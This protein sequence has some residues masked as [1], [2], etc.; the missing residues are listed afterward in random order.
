MYKELTRS[1]EELLA[2]QEVVVVAISG[3]GGAGKS[4][5]AD[6]LAQQFSVAESQ[7]V[8]VDG[9]HAKNYMQKKGIFELHDWTT[10][11]DILMHARTNNR[12]EY[13][14]RNDKEEESVVDV[15]RPQLVILE[16][17]RLIRPEVLP[18]VD[19]SVWI[20][21][22]L[23]VATERAVKRNRQQGDSEAEIALWYSKWVPESK[24][25]IEQVAPRDIVSFVYSDWV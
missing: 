10:I 20:D 23:D 14:K 1:I 15:P 22:P 25:Y 7:I 24:S 19:M 5:L 16:G 4:T 2:Q 17:I 13:L 9:L 21:C 18:Y 3:H 12:L 8:R 6:K 11:M